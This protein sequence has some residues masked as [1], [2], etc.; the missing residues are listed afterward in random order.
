MKKERSKEVK[1]KWNYLFV[2]ILFK[3]SKKET[4]ISHGKK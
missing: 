3:F 4:A 2:N 1:K